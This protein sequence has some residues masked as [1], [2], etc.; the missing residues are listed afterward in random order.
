MVYLMRKVMLSTR[1][2]VNEEAKCQD[3]VLTRDGLDKILG[4]VPTPR[5]QV[6][7]DPLLYG[8][9]DVCVLRIARGVWV[10]D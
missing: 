9:H 1:M 5:I 8:V 6:V 10:E 2:S 3:D 4:E 7:E